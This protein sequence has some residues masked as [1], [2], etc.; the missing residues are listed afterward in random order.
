MT[1]NQEGSPSYYEQKLN[2]PNA[3]G[4]E[5]S[6]S[7]RHPKSWTLSPIWR[8]KLNEEDVTIKCVMS[9]A[10]YCEQDIVFNIKSICLSS[11]SYL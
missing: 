2:E 8:G 9:I 6:W 1:I 3:F 7:L 5:D 4:K 11:R 10:E